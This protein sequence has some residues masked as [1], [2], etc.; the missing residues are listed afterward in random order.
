MKTKQ[1]PINRHNQESGFTLI[2][3]IM[4]I[5]VLGILAAAITPQFM[6]V[7]SEASKATS[8]KLYGDIKSTMQT[9]FG[10]HR[11]RQTTASNTPSHDDGNSVWITNCTSLYVYI[12]QTEMGGVTC[13]GTTLTFPDARTAALTA[14]TVTNSATIGD[15]TG[16]TT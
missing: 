10:L 4:V 7:S 6:D 11:A 2:E 12:P 1:T 13:D 14:E 3:L 15:L 16:S 9:A 8:E 5:V